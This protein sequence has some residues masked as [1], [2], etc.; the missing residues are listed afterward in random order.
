QVESL[1]R[2]GESRV[3]VLVFLTR[4][5]G[6]TLL[7]NEPQLVFELSRGEH[8][9]VELRRIG[10]RHIEMQ[11]RTFLQRVGHCRHPLVTR[12]IERCIARLEL[13]YVHLLTTTEQATEQ[14]ERRSRDLREQSDD[15]FPD[16]GSYTELRVIETA[17]DGQVDVDDS[18]SILEQCYRKLQ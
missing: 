5:F 9:S 1:R 10:H 18:V 2:I 16:D 14:R 8:G 11:L 17:A 15:G 6:R 7:R 3:G 4:P 13:D 12:R